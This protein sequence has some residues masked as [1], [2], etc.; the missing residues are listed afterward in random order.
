M[1]HFT[2]SFILATVLLA[3]L[4]LSSCTSLPIE[5]TWK[6]E[7]KE[8]Q[9]GMTMTGTRTFT[10][11]PDGR[12]GGTFAETS[13]GKAVL[14]GLGEVTFTASFPG[15]YTIEKDRVLLVNDTTAVKSNVAFHPTSFI[16]LLGAGSMGG[17]V[18]SKPPK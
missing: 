7:M 1:N 14:D 4:A 10:F 3:S 11:T 13:E 16:G 18:G 8:E 9:T 12:K 5:G 6:T 2:N 15:T 17:L